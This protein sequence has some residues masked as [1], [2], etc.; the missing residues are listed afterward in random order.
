MAVTKY[1]SYFQK[2]NL[3]CQDTNPQ[4]DPLEYFSSTLDSHNNPLMYNYNLFA[5]KR[6]PCRILEFQVPK[7][8]FLVLV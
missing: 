4:R 6:L 3:E 1:F 7:A 2:V 5:V 8:Y